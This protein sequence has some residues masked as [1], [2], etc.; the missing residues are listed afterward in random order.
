MQIKSL[1]CNSCGADLKVNP[2][3]RYF[4]CAHCGASLMLKQS[5][6]VYFTQLAEDIRDN[7][8]ELVEHSEKLLIE[9]E[10][11]R[12][13]REW[14]VER[15]KYKVSNSNGASSYPNEDTSKSNLS[16]FI[17]IAF[18][19]IFGISFM[20]SKANFD[21]DFDTSLHEINEP[22]KNNNVTYFYDTNKKEKKH[23]KKADPFS[24]I[25]LILIIVS[26][27]GVLDSMSKSNVN[28][29]NYSKAKNQYLAK[30]N[31]LLKELDN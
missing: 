21:K 25:F 24:F 20:I 14:L 2:K 10:V 8:D 12:L 31:K 15:E 27:M 23:S 30:R 26:V 11:E 22:P 29:D 5:G 16:G 7:T 4:T 6:S 1:K 13:D 3:I 9:K 19:L 18:I 28:S 17:M